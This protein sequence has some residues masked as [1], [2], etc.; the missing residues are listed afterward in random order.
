MANRMNLSQVRDAIAST[1]RYTHSSL[2]LHPLSFLCTKQQRVTQVYSEE[3]VVKGEVGIYTKDEEGGWQLFDENVCS[4]YI[5]KQP[6]HD[7]FRVVSMN[8]S[9]KVYLSLLSL[10]LPHLPSPLLLYIFS[11][12]YH[13]SLIKSTKLIL[14]MI[15][16]IF[17]M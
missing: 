7:M 1:M 11:Q 6:G 15:N 10:F 5:Y 4:L 14:I 12:Y 3:V 8:P 13:S 2:F 17:L 16:I 9:R